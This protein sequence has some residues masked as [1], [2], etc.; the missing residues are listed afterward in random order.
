MELVN[1]ILPRKK[2]I[3]VHFFFV[4]SFS[5]LYVFSCKI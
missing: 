4:Y 1:Q 2:K 5:K 3:K